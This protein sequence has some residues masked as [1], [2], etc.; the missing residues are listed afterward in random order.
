MGKH[1]H[2][3]KLEGATG[4]IMLIGIGL[5][6]LLEIGFWPWILVVVGLASLPTSVANDGLWAGMQ[7]SL[8]LIG[9]ALLFALDVFWPGILILVG[10]SVLIGAIFR[11]PMLEGEKKK[12]GL[13]TSDAAGYDDEYEDEV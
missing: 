9:I 3:D 4:G 5:I 2:K 13:P 10:L 1:K 8:W 7:G 11:P 12:K 6:F